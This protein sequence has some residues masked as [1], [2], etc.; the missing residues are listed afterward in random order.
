MATLWFRRPIRCALLLV[1]A[2]CT[3]AAAQTTDP[4]YLAD[5]PSVDRVKAQ[6]QGTD[7]TDTAARQ[8][9]VFTYLQE[10][11]KRIKYNKSSR[12]PFTP[13]E[14]RV[15][16]AYSVAGYQIQQDYAKSHTPD[17]TKAFNFTEAKYE[18]SN[19]DEWARSLIGSQS[20]AAY[21]GTLDVDYP[22]PLRAIGQP[23]II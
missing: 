4:A 18:M 19:G 12:T 8:M 10:Y 13:D 21:K 17:E 14:S 5:M 11:I 9:A 22:H 16:G 3:F 15:M 6:I 23:R 20:A 7:P 1:L 2:S